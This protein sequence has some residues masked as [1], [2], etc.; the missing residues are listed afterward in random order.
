MRV[1]LIAVAVLGVSLPA[2]A[3]SARL[4]ADD[5]PVNSSSGAKLLPVVPAE[6]PAVDDGIPRYVPHFG[7]T[8]AASF[9][10]IPT[11]FAVANL[12]GTLSNNLIGAAIPGL[13]AMV[14][15]APTISTLVAWL[16]GNWNSKDGFKPFNFWLPW[17]SSLLVH[18]A[19]MVVAG[20]LGVTIGVPATLFMMGAVE[21][22]LMS[23]AI[24]GTMHLTTNKRP[25][26]AAIQSFVPGVTDT[27]FISLAKVD[28]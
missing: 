12:L 7:V 10:S 17:G 26:G 14:L 3:Y 24:V 22:L 15:I 5:A 9:V 1:S 6:Y 23:G 19:S 8:F 13:L 27:R 16:Y 4:M 20:F 11:G 28:L 2:Q 18:I 25:A 21:G